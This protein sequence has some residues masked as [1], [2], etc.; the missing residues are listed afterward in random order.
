[1]SKQLR[2]TL[3]IATICAALVLV[4]FLWPHSA[5]SVAWKVTQDP[6]IVNIMR[7]GV[8]DSDLTTV[9]VSLPAE[10]IPAFMEQLRDTTVQLSSPLR[11][12]TFSTA[13]Y[14]IDMGTSGQSWAEVAIDEGGHFSLQH[15]QDGRIGRG[16]YRFS[17]PVRYAAL[18][19]V[20]HDYAGPD[21]TY[22]GHAFLREFFAIGKD[23]RSDLVDLK[24]PGGVYGGGAVE[25][26]YSGIEPYMT[27]HGFTKVLME[28][29]LYNLEYIC[30]QK[31][32]GWY[33]SNIE[34]TPN[35]EAGY[36]SYRVGLVENAS[37]NSDNLWFTGNY[38]VGEDGLV[39]NFYVDLN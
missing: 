22:P 30:K 34:I 24:A 39:D 18:L 4:I 38:S 11:Q 26:L 28:R 36:Y 2:N 15:R 20:C 7:R 14:R 1:M 33:C 10:E 27:E 35:S 6:Q 19:Q 37:G 23:G 16:I 21:A 17:D 8:G 9:S 3:I 31:G 13:S 12:S 25:T 29:S 32:S 5:A